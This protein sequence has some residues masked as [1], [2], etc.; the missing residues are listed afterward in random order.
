MHTQPPW[1]AHTVRCR[2]T[3]ARW[4]LRGVRIGEAAH[5]GPT[6]RASARA[7]R[8]L[9][10]APPTPGAQADAPVAGADGRPEPIADAEEPH[11]QMETEAV[12][13]DAP[14]AAPQAVQ[15]DAFAAAEE[16][17]AQAHVP[18]PAPLHPG[19]HP[20]PD[21]FFCA[22]CGGGADVDQL[23]LCDGCVCAWHTYCLP[24]PLVAVPDGDWYCPDCSCATPRGEPEAL[25]P[26]EAPVP[27][28]HPVDERGWAALSAIHLADEMRVRVRCMQA[29][30]PFL[31]GPLRTAYVTSLKQLRDAYEHHHVEAQ[32]QAW[33]LFRLTSRML[34]W[35]THA[36]GPSRKELE[37]RIARFQNGEWVALIREAR[38]AG[39]MRRRPRAAAPSEEETLRRRAERAKAC[40]RRG[41]VSRGRQVL[42][43][44]AL[45]PGTDATLEELRDP[46]RRPP[47]LTEPIP[48]DVMDFAPTAPLEFDR[49]RYANNLRSAPRGSAPGL[50]G[51]T[52]EHLK[53]LLDD[54]LATD[55]IAAAA[56]RLAHAQ[57]P[58]PIVDA[59]SLGSLT[60]LVKDNGRVRGIVA[61]DTFRRGVART[62]AQQSA[63]A[64]EAA[65]MPY[66][67]ALSTRA[68]TDCVARIVRALMEMDSSATLT[69]IDGIGAF[70]HMR[71]AAMLRA[72][73]DNEELQG[74]LPF[75]RQFY[76]RQSNY[77]WYDDTGAAH[78]V[79]QG[80]GGEQGDPLMP[81]LYALGQHPALVEVNAALREG[82]L[83]FAFL[84]DIYVLSAPERVAD[85]FHMVAAAL[86]RHAGIR[87]NLGK[88]KVWNAAGCK[89]PRMEEIGA[90]AWTGDAPPAQ[91]G[92]VVLGTPVGDAAFVQRWLEEKTG[93]HRA[94]L[95]RI[96]LVPDAQCASLLLLMCASPRV[97]HTLRN[98]PPAEV[99]TFAQ[100]HDRGLMEC[101]A[102][103]LDS[104]VPPEAEEIAQL[105]FREGGL[106]LRCARRM[107]PGAYWASWA[108]CISQI[109]A[110]APII[111]N[112]LLADLAR[113][114][115]AASP[116][117]RAASAA[118]DVVQQEGFEVPAWPEFCD[119]DFRA[120]QP[121]G[122]E[123]G[124]WRHGWQYHACAARDTHFAAHVH[125]P[126]LSPDLQGLRASQ[127]GPC[128]SR[129]FTALPTTPEAVFTPEQFRTLVLVRLHRPLHLDG[130]RCRCGAMLDQYGHHRSACS[131][132][133]LLGHRG[134]PAE[135]CTARICREAGARVRE[136]E[137]LRDLNVA[138][139]PGDTRKIEVIANG[140]TLWGGRQ[141]AIDTTVVSALNGRGQA[142]SR[143][144][145]KALER[146]RKAKERRYPE[147]VGDAPRCRLVV[148]AFEVGGRWSAEAVE[149]LRLLARHRAQASPRLLRRSAAALFFQRWTALLAC[150]VQRAFAAS[151]L[152]EPLPGQ[153]CVSGDPALLSSLDRLL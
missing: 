6:T 102:R 38:A 39:T 44:A 88:T 130:R 19:A 104:E 117:V 153:A 21:E 134:A 142:R 28:L 84:D 1:C 70:D 139:P 78:D 62:L 138:V 7:A 14:I 37:E 99:E 129:H 108:D 75:V 23:V 146:A 20:P 24:A 40:V 58:E 74:L 114:T 87:V 57:V 46:E 50:A 150:S 33:V 89:P 93:E 111:C 65:C 109:N 125:L 5:P 85:I 36:R 66:Q 48:P 137:L 69:S 56:E 135:V 60:A 68:G 55:L 97:V 91:R 73:R 16:V 86:E 2:R 31:R 49:E 101:L 80:E 43:A 110:R 92:I 105:P 133:G 4:G 51:D 116:S 15:P 29:V 76:G 140:L 136:G 119:P 113:G 67:Y 54:E 47:H 45:A 61:G 126:S 151:L 149:F 148:L 42:C 115:G 95:E 127:R 41:E 90:E 98:L 143:A 112:R 35:R 147:L 121:T 71:R 13:V 131:T 123:P 32:T 77:L 144:P 82:E 17:H 64:V 18:A 122:H 141:L 96:P 81:A 132:A 83:I 27:L 118:A 59:L 145:G 22:Q 52:N 107:A 26:E 63:D 10:D 25:L 72:L 79:L 53:V 12:H 103:I 8:V 3:A 34:L 11:A 100:A 120:P 30:P 152:G 94:L 128:A 106:G 9:R 124:E